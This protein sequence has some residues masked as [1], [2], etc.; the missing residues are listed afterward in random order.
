MAQ[1]IRVSGVLKSCPWCP[2]THI[3]CWVNLFD[4]ICIF[5]VMLWIHRTEQRRCSGI[6]ET[7]QKAQRAWLGAGR[8][9]NENLAKSWGKIIII[10]NPKWKK[11]DVESEQLEWNILA[12]WKF[13]WVLG[14]TQILSKA[15]NWVYYIQERFNTVFSTSVS[16]ALQPVSTPIPYRG[17]VSDGFGSWGAT[18]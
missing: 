7:A 17:K 11:L 8:L 14:L 12:R 13:A 3:F 2:R 6:V 9:M 18:I 1:L 10:C 5:Q 4:L 15:K 16:N